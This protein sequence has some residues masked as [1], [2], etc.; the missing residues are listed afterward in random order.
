MM[1]LVLAAVIYAPM[2]IV[3]AVVISD[4]IAY[5]KSEGVSK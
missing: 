1:N 2:L 5:D 4:G 3:A